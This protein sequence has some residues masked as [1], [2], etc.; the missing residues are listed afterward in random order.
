M[1]NFAA[2]S[3]RCNDIVPE[4]ALDQGQ[5]EMTKAAEAARTATKV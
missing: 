3:D 1:A 5:L 4:S 2:I